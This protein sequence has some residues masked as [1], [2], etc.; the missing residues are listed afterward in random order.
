VVQG[1]VH[2]QGDAWAWTLN[3]LDRAVQDTT[4][5]AASSMPS[6]AMPARIA[7]RAASSGMQ[8]TCT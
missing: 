7:A 3:Q 5:A 6:H 8:S 1:F 4:R 2:N